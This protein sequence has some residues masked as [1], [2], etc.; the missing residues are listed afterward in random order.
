MINNLIKK[1][2]KN[3]ALNLM[4]RAVFIICVFS[5]FAF[6]QTPNKKPVEN[7]TKIE[8]SPKITQ[9]DETNIAEV[10]KPNGKPLLVNFWATWCV[11]CREE[12]PDLVEID[13]QFKGKIDFITITLDD[14]AEINRDVPKFLIEM[15]A[16]MPTY[17]LHTNKENEVIASVSK[18][19]QGGLPF[20]IFYDANGKVLHT[21]M[22][23]IKPEIVKAKINES[24]MQNSK[25]DATEIEKLKM[26]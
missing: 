6:A 14:L 21:R 8:T 19:W 22:G 16:E 3:G 24:L 1:L 5:V 7:T 2:C 4:F 17:L 15:K 25:N 23:K 9:I 20:T 26:P 18:D 11:P 10:L 12:F 13:K